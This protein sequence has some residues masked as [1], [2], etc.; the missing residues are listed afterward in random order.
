MRNKAHAFLLR[1][2]VSLNAIFLAHSN[3]FCLI[4][5]CAEGNSSSISTS[6]TVGDFS[7]DAGCNPMSMLLYEY[8][9]FLGKSQ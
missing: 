2:F 3:W 1:D 6:E 8:M 4:Q 7:P 5:H 9:H